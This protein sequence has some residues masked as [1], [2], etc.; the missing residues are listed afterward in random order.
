MCTSQILPTHRPKDKRLFIVDLDQHRIF[1]D[2]QP[3]ARI[4]WQQWLPP[5]P[6]KVLKARLTR[7]AQAVRLE[8][9]CGASSCAPALP[10][11]CLRCL[12]L[13]QLL[14]RCRIQVY[15]VILG[16]C[17]TRMR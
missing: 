16:S 3:W 6:G 1:D 9:A 11:L 15:E 13:T 2:S 7:A 5:G 4:N 14:G 8:P 10:C 17:L 12:V